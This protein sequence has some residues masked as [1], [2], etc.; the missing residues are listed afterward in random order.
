MLRNKIK[1]GLMQ[2]LISNKEE[3]YWNVKRISIKQKNEE[4]IKP[5]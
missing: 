3:H 4:D 2:L 1:S 5:N